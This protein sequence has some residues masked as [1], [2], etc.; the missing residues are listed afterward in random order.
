MNERIIYPTDDG[1]AIIIPAPDCGLSI[2]EV[3]RKD[4]PAG[5]PYKIVDASDIPTDR[6]FRNAWEVEI[7]DPDGVGLGAD[8]W[9]A[10]QEALNDNN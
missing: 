9:F 2:E 7:T 3:A 6:T 5:T 1:V 10:E 8:A 4:V